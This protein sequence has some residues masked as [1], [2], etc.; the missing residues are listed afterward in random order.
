LPRDDRTRNEI[1][2]SSGIFRQ[3]VK[4][5]PGARLIHRAHAAPF[6]KGNNSML[7]NLRIWKRRLGLG[8]SRTIRPGRSGPR[9]GRLHIE[10]L[11]DRLAPT[12][13]TFS[14]LEF[15]TTGTFS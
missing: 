8:K 11:E 10:T 1:T 9:Q 12:I 4:P 13:Q 15:M 6:T 5:E 3:P 7:K 2:E 14:G